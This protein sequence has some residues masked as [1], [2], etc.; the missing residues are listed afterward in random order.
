MI[1]HHSKNINTFMKQNHLY[2]IIF[3]FFIIVTLNNFNYLNSYMIHS[4]LESISSVIAVGIF[5]FSLNSYSVNNN[6]FLIKLGIGYLFVAIFD[7]VHT[8]NYG[9]LVIIQNAAYD[10]DTKLWVAGRFVELCTLLNAST[11]LFKKNSKFDY[12]ITFIIFTILS[13]ILM[14]DAIYINIIIP[15]LKTETS[16]V[17]PFKI[18][19]EYVITVGFSLCAFIYYKYRDFFDN[20]LFI[21]LELFLGTKIISELFIM[22]YNT[23]IDNYNLIGHLFKVLSFYFLYKG[24]IAAGIKSP[25]DMMANNLEKVDKSLKEHETQRKY[26]EHSIIN[27]D[28]CNDLLINSSVNGIMIIRYCEIIYVNDTY[29]NLLAAK[30]Y[31][32]IKGKNIIEFI[33]KDYIPLF[34]ERLENINAENKVMPFDEIK[35]ISLDGSFIDVEV[36]VN[37]INY[38]GKPA[39]MIIA[40][41]NTQKKKLENEIIEGERKLN[42]S[43]ELNK[44]HSEFFSNISHELKTPLNIILGSIQLAENSH[45]ISQV[46]GQNT[47]DVMDIMK[48]NTYRLIRLTNNLI[49]ISKYDTGYL[50]INRHNH[51]IVNIVEDITFS[52]GQYFKYKD[53]N[54]IFDTDVE[55]KVMAV[56]VDIIERIV[57]NLL[58]NAVK[59]T[60]KNDEIMVCI[61]DLGDKVAISVKDNGIG[62]PKEKISTIFNRFEQVDRSYTRNREG[63]GIGLSLVK[64]LTELHGGSVDVKSVLGEG[65]EFIIILPS[66]LIEDEEPEVAFTSDSKIDRISIE[67]SDIYYNE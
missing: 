64:T 9:N 31:T 46:C 67:F 51:D 18:I 54:I 17:T 43:Y 29:I 20:S 6:D 52:V 7:L 28:K 47:Y 16:G 53:K 44:L 42:A 61:F 32:E 66:T 5:M 34:Y 19:A 62:I 55:E 65:S 48:Q 27:N 13:T 59:F 33:H 35:V 25:F 24:I 15:V 23:I 40:K 41:D 14:I 36:S 50:K 3:M 63:S 8:Y 11:A 45:E 10:L 58:S 2:I 49:D 12:S 22:V 39:L 1:E 37:N 57:M 60:R 26:L 56:D 4:I 38:R 30:D 21:Y